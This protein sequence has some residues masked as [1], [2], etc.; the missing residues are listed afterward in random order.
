MNIKKMKEM[1]LEWSD[2]REHVWDKITKKYYREMLKGRIWP[3][4]AWNIFN[5]HKV[6]KDD[7]SDISS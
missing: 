1:D 6:A 7:S 2:F 4:G 3:H 5:K